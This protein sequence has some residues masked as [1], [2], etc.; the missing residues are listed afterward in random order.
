MERQTGAHQPKLERL[1]GGGGRC[2]E[3]SRPTR[4]DRRPL[5]TELL[6]FDCYVGDEPSLEQ[7]QRGQRQR[8]EASETRGEVLFAE[9]PRVFVAA[10]N[11]E[12]NMKR[13]TAEEKKGFAE[14]DQI[15]WGSVTGMGAVKVWKGAE[16]QTLREKYPDRIL[17]SRMVRRKKPMPGVGCFKF[18][19]QWCVLGFVDPDGD[20]LR[21]FAATPQS[22]VI[23]IFFQAALRLNLNVVFGD[24][25]SAFC[26]G[27][28]LVRAQDRLFASRAKARVLILVTLWSCLLPSMAWTTHRSTGQRPCRTFCATILASGDAIWTLAC[29]FDRTL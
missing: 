9:K 4:A 10:R 27:K 12:F 21:T 23:S 22:E 16:A 6:N 24:V 7:L 28:R 8:A 17:R 14:S 29:T 15:E 18:K 5:T 1:A 26:R 19:S 11:D 3:A 20:G 13:A 2:R 25:T